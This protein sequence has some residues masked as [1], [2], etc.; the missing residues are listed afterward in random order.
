MMALIRKNTSPYAVSIVCDR[1]GESR[2]VREDAKLMNC[3]KV[4]VYKPRICNSRSKKCGCRFELLGYRSD[5]KTED[6]QTKWRLGVVEGRHN[7]P[8]T[9][10]LAGNAFMGRM[11]PDEECLARKWGDGRNTPKQIV[12]KLRTDNPGNVTKRKQVANFL[13]KLHFEDRGELTVTQWALKFLADNEYAFSPVRDMNTNE[14]QILFF[15]H[16]ESLR[17]LKKFPYVVIV[18]ATYKTNNL[19]LMLD[20]ILISDEFS[21]V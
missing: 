20:F 3:G 1:Y 9:F 21:I 10:D 17:L 19:V 13:Y 2:R 15:A 8:P 18:D 6:S 16:K 11:T 5:K 12:A 14:V 4:P 7:H